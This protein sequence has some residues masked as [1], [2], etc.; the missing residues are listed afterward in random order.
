[1]GRPTTD[2]TMY[3]ML[4]SHGLTTLTYVRDSVVGSYLVNK[5][6]KAQISK[7]RW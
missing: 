1:M 2:Y 6:L 5:L 7:H 4:L 3:L